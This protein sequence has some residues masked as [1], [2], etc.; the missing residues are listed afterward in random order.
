M[1]MYMNGW[2][3]LLVI[4]KSINNT[5][6]ELKKDRSQPLRRT[7]LEKFTLWSRY[8]QRIYVVSDPEV[9]PTILLSEPNW[10]EWYNRTRR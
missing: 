3:D 10:V 9:V 6:I 4:G 2:P 7:Q 5:W 1:G 8:G